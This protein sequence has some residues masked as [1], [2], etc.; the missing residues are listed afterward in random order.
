MQVSGVGCQVSGAELGI[1]DTGYGTRETRS[2][3]A[4]LRILNRKWRVARTG[5]VLGLATL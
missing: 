2:L 3:K 1:R 5:K 4:L